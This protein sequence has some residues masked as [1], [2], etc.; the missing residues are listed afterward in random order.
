MEPATS[1]SA[2]AKPQTLQGRRVILWHGFCSVHKRFTVGQIKPARLR[3]PDVRVIVHPE[4]PMEVVDAA[5]E[6]GSTDFITQSD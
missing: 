4:C 1:R 2:A 5:D 6:S 3:F